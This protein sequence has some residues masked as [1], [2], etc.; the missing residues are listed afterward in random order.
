MKI[1]TLLSWRKAAADEPIETNVIRQV[2]VAGKF[3][4]FNLLKVD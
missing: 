4:Y 2:G 3:T 1:L